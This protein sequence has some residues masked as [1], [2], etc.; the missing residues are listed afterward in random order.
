M[1]VISIEK[2]KRFEKEEPYG[3]MHAHFSLYLDV[4]RGREAKKKR[5]TNEREKKEEEMVSFNKDRFEADDDDGIT[6]PSRF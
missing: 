3:I 2:N 4:F 1:S 5:Q 6:S